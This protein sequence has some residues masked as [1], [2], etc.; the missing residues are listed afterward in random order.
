MVLL[1]L[2]LSKLTAEQKGRIYKCTSLKSPTSTSSV[3]ETVL[4]LLSAKSGSITGHNIFVDSG[5]I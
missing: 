2:S 1:T 3:A 5:T 4:F